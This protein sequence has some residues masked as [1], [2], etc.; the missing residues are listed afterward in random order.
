MCF[1]AKRETDEG[2]SYSHVYS[3][4]W[5]GRYIRSLSARAR[6]P[7]DFAI[8]PRAKFTH[9][10]TRNKTKQLTF[11]FMSLVAAQCWLLRL[12]QRRAT[13]QLI[14]CIIRRLVTL[15]YFFFFIHCAIEQ[16][17]LYIYNPM[18]DDKRAKLSLKNHTMGFSVRRIVG[19]SAETADKSVKMRFLIDSFVFSLFFFIFF[20]CETLDARVEWR[21]HSR[22][23]K[24]NKSGSAERV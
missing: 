17:N 3:P 22:Q 24:L 8:T 18:I 2:E 6:N 1:W 9:T 5:P 19:A 15:S 21:G 23:F 20:A 13:N 11:C 14:H 12:H 4:K 10:H 16:K 7:N